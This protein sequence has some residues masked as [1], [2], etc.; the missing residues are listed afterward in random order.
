[1]NGAADAMASKFADDLESAAADF[2]FDGAANILGTI[3]CARSDERMA[4][5]ARSTTREFVRYLAGWR[6]FYGDGRVRVV[7]VLF[8]SEIKFDEVAGLNDAIA[9]NSMNHFVV[10]ADTRITGKIV[11]HGRRRASA[12]GGENSCA[13]F[14]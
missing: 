3:A 13:G 1:V 2:A 9:G 8:G 11:N 6:N 12:M 4:E 5:G 7:A 10:D 14:G